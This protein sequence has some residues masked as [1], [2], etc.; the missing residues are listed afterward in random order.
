MT[1]K[2]MV[3]SDCQLLESYQTNSTHNVPADTL[4]I[5]RKSLHRKL[6]SVEAR[7]FPNKVD[8]KV[9]SDVSRYTIRL[10][11]FQ[12]NLIRNICMATLAEKKLRQHNKQTNYWES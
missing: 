7:R 8:D 4:F 9:V 11:Q 2:F 10:S 12:R 3:L 5:Y 1:E 6:H